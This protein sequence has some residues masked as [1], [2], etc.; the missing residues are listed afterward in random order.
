MTESAAVKVNG[1]AVPMQLTKGYVAID[2]TWKAGDTV[3]VSLP[4]P[5]RRVVA[6]SEVAADRGRVALQSG[7]L[8]YTAEWTDN[9]KGKV[10]NLTLP[11]TAKLTAEWQPALLK[12]VTVVK[13][14]AVALQTNAGGKV[15]KIEQ[16]F[17]GIPYYAWA[18]RGRGQM[19]VW[20]PN[21]EA[22]ARPAAFPTVATSAKI[23]VSSNPHRH[24]PGNIN[25]GED[26]ASSSDGAAY[27]DWWNKNGSAE[28]VDMTF[29]RPST[30]SE[31][32]LYWFDDTGHGGVRVPA[33]WKLLYQ[34]GGQWKP[35]EA[36]GSY[37]VARD[38][39]NKVTFKPVSTTA[40]RL[41]LQAQP[42]VSMGVQEWKVK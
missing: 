21:A 38:T 31:A 27:F 42:N 7:P 16:D 2:R 20:I 24:N 35:V 9:P 12:G 17:V 26:P 8:V 30:V 6:N 25:D 1:K 23:T 13:A 3:E 36:I 10:R 37:G 40:L 11:D 4:M 14:R 39:Y 22:S 5:V 32:Q 28:W 33:A 41:E 19:M 34:D 29:E 18:N 15:E